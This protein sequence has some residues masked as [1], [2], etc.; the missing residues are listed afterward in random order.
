LRLGLVRLACRIRSPQTM[1]A[2]TYRIPS[3]NFAEWVNDEVRWASFTILRTQ[4]GTCSQ[5]IPSAKLAF[6]TESAAWLG[7]YLPVLL[8]DLNPDSFSYADR[9]VPEIGQLPTRSSTHRGL[10]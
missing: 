6:L 3:M 8:E 4:G 1:R 7:A 10:V 9:I 5:M 2:L